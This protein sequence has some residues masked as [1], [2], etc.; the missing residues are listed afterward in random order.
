MPKGLDIP[1]DNKA[2]P[3]PSNE[4]VEQTISNNEIDTKYQWLKHKNDSIRGFTSFTP[5]NVNKLLEV[6]SDGGTLTEGARAIGVSRRTVYN[7]YERSE[8]SPETS[9][10]S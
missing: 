8:E 9:E 10:D 1:D 2:L 7:W 3:E 5:E 4:L 6:V